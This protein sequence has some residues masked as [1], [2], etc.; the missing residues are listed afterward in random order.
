MRPVRM[1]GGGRLYFLRQLRFRFAAEAVGEQTRRKDHAM[2]PLLPAGVRCAAEVFTRE[3]LGLPYSNASVDA[4]CTSTL[5][6][7]V[8]TSSD[9]HA[10]MRRVSGGIGLYVFA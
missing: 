3:G 10:P 7:I 1:N 6:I 8:G 9:K 5:S 2:W 4:A